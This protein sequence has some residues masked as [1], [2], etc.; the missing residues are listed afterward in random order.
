[1]AAVKQNG[2]ALRDASDELKGDRALVMVALE[3][4]HHT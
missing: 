2:G 3:Q 4:L 1:M